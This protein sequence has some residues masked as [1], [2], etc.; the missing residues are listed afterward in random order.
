MVA[1]ADGGAAHADT[2]Q[3]GAEKLC[4]DWIHCGISFQKMFEGKVVNS[5]ARVQRVVE[6]D[7]RQDR[8]HVGL[9]ER[10]Q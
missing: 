7:A 9:Q 5:V 8:E 2:G 3:A 1:D 10:D 4:C 6:I